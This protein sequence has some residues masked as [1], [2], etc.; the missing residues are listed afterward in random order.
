M[1]SMQAIRADRKPLVPLRQLAH[2]LLVGVVGTVA[3]ASFP[4]TSPG[5]AGPTTSSSVARGVPA[6]PPTE[7]MPVRTPAF[8]TLAPEPL[9]PEVVAQAVKEAAAAAPEPL[10]S[11]APVPDIGV[12]AAVTKLISM[13]EVN[14]WDGVGASAG[15]LTHV[16]PLTLLESIGPPQ[17]GRIPIRLGGADVQATVWIEATAVSPFTQST[18]ARPWD[19]PFAFGESQVRLTVPYRTQLDGSAAA[20]ANCGPASLGMVLDAFG[21]SVATSELRE[22]ANRFQGTSGPYTGFNL[23]PLQRVTETYDLAGEGLFEGDRYRRWTL[24]DVRH[25]LQ[26][27]HPVIPQ[28]KYR[29]IPGREGAGTNTDHYL[30]LTG[31]DGEDFLFN[32]PIPWGSVSQ[33]R[34]TAAQLLR[35]WMN[36]DIPGAALAIA[37]P[38][39]R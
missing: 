30:V 8:T 1:G 21:V 28:L 37:A 36:S 15:R 9:P 11:D 10:A 34:I 14:V 7:W 24:D 35:A 2:V 27:G 38:P 32:D 13:Q 5:S 6:S 26:A 16:P 12:A 20:G 29:L 23:G 31:M 25:H 18:A 33:G 3:W 22:R 39:N 4:T 17:Q 19:R